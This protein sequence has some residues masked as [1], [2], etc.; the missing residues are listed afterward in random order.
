MS[1]CHP[2]SLQCLKSALA[3]L[4]EAVYWYEKLP[5]IPPEMGAPRETL[6]ELLFNVGEAA[7]AIEW[8]LEEI[9]GAIDHDEELG[10]PSF[11]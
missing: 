1:R 7:G 10:K 8:T 11:R 9:D 4:T 5:L 3:H 6:D 2:D